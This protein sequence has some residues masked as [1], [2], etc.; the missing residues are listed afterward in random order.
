MFFF[1]VVGTP[2]FEFS[3]MSLLCH[4]FEKRNK[5]YQTCV[6]RKLSLIRKYAYTKYKFIIE[7]P[8]P[9]VERLSCF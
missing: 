8:R 1:V 9:R 5:T 2:F 6:V 3:E 4:Y 7:G